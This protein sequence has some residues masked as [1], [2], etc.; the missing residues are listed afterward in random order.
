[1]KQN[2]V[3]EPDDIA[4]RIAAGTVARREA[5]YA[6]EVR[7]LLDAAL[8]VIAERGTSSRVRVADVVSSAGLS[9]DAFYRH[10]PSKDALIVAILQDGTERLAR[11]LAHQM[12]KESLPERKVR[13]WV[14]G[15][16]SQT[17]EKTAGTT[18]AVLWNGS[19]FGTGDSAGRHDPSEALA[20][21]LIEPFTAL[22]CSTP[23]LAASL[24]SHA[25]I[26][27]VSDHLWAGTRPSRDETDRISAFCVAAARV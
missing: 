22:G 14:E 4:A 17:D 11:Y 10:F 20:V 15:M 12:D 18:L 16:L 19:G 26:G 5:E 23:E 13:R 8:A 24:V 1:V 7:R 9:N 25:A 6:S 2:D 21:L 27:R 3:R